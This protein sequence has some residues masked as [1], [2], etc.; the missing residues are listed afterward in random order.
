MTTSHIDDNTEKGS[1]VVDDAADSDANGS[2]LVPYEQD[3]RNPWN[4]GQASRLLHTIIP[5][6]NSFLMSVA[7]ATPCP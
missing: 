7:V 4:W 2:S 6:V 3:P 5:G 1:S